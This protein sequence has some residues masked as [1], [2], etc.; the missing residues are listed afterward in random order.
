M[1]LYGYTFEKD[2]TYYEKAELNT[3]DYRKLA[4]YIFSNP[5]KD[6]MITDIWDLPILTTFG[7]FINQIDESQINRE[8]LLAEISKLEKEREDEAL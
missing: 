1:I 7:F 3:N 8:L 4:K 5:C 6:K 2:A